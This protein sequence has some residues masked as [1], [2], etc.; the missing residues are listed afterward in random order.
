MSE[1]THMYLADLNFYQKLKN[2]HQTDR[3]LMK[4]HGH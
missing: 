4:D 3:I 2:A 1:K